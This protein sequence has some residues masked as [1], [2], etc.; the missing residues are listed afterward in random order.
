MHNK[1]ALGIQCKL[2]IL[3]KVTEKVI[4]HGITGETI[5]YPGFYQV[6]IFGSFKA[7][8]VLTEKH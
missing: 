5:A 8:N 1:L 3:I 7:F 2:Q 4:K 6:K